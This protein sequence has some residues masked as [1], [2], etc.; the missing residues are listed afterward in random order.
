MKNVKISSKIIAVLFISVLF[1]SCKKKDSANPAPP[2]PMGTLAFHLH[3]NIDS[4]EADSGLVC[5]DASGRQI[6]LSS[7]QFYASGITAVKSDGSTVTMSNV[8]ILKTI[9]NE[10]YVIGTVPAGN[11]NSVWF[12]VGID[13]ATNQTTPSSHPASS[14]LS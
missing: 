7:A 14:V 11:Y 10:E 8:Y 4:T 12:N 5:H 13:A 6:K 3:T 2:T 1:F 9:A